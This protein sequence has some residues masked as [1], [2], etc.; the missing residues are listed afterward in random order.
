[1]LKRV[2]LTS[3]LLLVSTAVAWAQS[4]AVQ[5]GVTPVPSGIWV[6][7]FLQA[8][9]PALVAVILS[10][11]V[12]YLGKI[13]KP[14]ATGLANAIKD[15]RVQGAAKRAIDYGV[16]AVENATKNTVW[17]IPTTN[18]VLNAAVQY[19]IK[20]EPAFSEWTADQIKAYVYA[21]LAPLDAVP[22]D[23]SAVKVGLPTVSKP[24]VLK[25]A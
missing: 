1:M 12:T 10:L 4:T 18:A 16:G 13:G 6:D 22:A 15:S 9:E 23:A 24:T 8:V 2:S 21:H 19:A 11:A 5:V 7:D 20:I 14:W 3:G 25:T 17:D